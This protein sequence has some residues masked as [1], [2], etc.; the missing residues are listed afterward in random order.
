MPSIAELY[1][2]YRNRSAIDASFAKIRSLPNGG[3]YADEKLAN[4]SYCSSS[5][6]PDRDRSAWGTKFSNGE[7]TWEAKFAGTRVCCLSGF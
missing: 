5:Q 6:D 7:V 3:N 2:V 4:E 1:E